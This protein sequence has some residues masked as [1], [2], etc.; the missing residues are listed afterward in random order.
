MRA[1]HSR[2][3]RRAST[4]DDGRRPPA[5]AR[6][7]T[8]PAWSSRSAS[9]RRR[10]SPTRAGAQRARG[11]ARRAQGRSGSTA[12]SSTRSC[13]T[14]RSAS[15]TSKRFAD[16]AKAAQLEKR[17][18][19]GLG[20][21]PEERRDYPQGRVGA[22]VIGYAGV[23]NKG[24]TASRSVRQR[25]DG[26]ARAAG[27][28]CATR[29]QA[30]D[31]IA[32]QPERAGADV[33][34]TIDHT[35]QAK[36]EAVLRETVEEWGA[37]A[38]TAIVLDPRTGDVLAMAQAP[39]YDANN[40][41]TRPRTAAQPRGHRH[42][43][44]GIDVQ[45]RHRRRACSP[46]AS[47]RR[48]RRSRSPYSIQV[49][50]RIIHDARAAPT[51]T[52]TVAQILAYSRTSARSRSRRSSARRSLAAWIDQFGFGQST[53]ID[54]PGESPGSCCRSSNGRARRSATSR[55]ARASR[56][57]R[58]RWPRS[59]ARSRTTASGCSRT[60]SSA[61][62]AAPRSSRRSGGSCRRTVAAQMKA[63]LPRRRLGRGRHGHGGAVPGYTV[64]GKT[65]TAQKPDGHGGYSSSKYVASFV[66]MVPATKPAPRR[67]RRGRRAERSDL[68][69]RRRRAGVR[70]DRPSSLVELDVSRR[71]DE[72]ERADAR[73]L[74]R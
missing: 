50:D 23:D 41:A 55:S 3:S 30:I 72:P 74:L 53:G 8:A 58:C 71:I 40:S 45:A 1:A 7:S 13:R 63:M 22:Q 16:P 4:G 37:K 51:E 21:Y 36:A 73:R 15:S 46:R 20:F 18:L 25:A 69:R 32:S 66:G 52:I 17:E 65:G 12:T 57:R 31:V 67:A 38:A 56:S 49:A 5:A 39:G 33:W 6:S 9:R 19:A 10:C 14:A 35:I 26:P 62:A 28:S 27:R 11:R 60:S 24:L 68:G 59:T 29:G 48:R 47:S 42:V 34:P 70:G 2:A 43:R 64:A 54:F 44:A 61:S